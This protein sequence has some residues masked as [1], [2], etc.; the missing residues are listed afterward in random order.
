M[1]FAKDLTLQDMSDFHSVMFVHR[2]AKHV[3]IDDVLS[4]KV[5]GLMFLT[6]F[7]GFHV[8]FELG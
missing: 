4:K 7:L 8:F 5:E 1:D 6:C 2:R 3:L